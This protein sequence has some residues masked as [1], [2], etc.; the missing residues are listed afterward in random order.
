M[1]KIKEERV[2]AD[3]KR[4][5]EMKTTF[6][7]IEEINEGSAGEEELFEGDILLNKEQQQRRDLGLPIMPDKRGATI[8]ESAYWPNNTLYYFFDDVDP[9]SDADKTVVRGALTSLEKFTCVRFIESND[10]EDYVNV[11]KGDS[12]K[13]WVG[14]QTGIQTLYLGQGCVYTGIIQ[15]EF[16]HALGFWHEQSRYDRDNYVEINWDNIIEGKEGNFEKKLEEHTTHQGFGYDYGSVMHYGFYSFAID[17]TIPTII[18]LRETDET[19]GQREF[20]SD[21]DIDELNRLYECDYYV[22]KGCWFDINL[23][24]LLE[25]LE[26]T[27]NVYLDGHYSMRTEPVRKCAFAAV[28]LGY[29]YFAMRFGG[30]CLVAT[31][32]S[33]Y[34]EEGP[35]DKCVEGLG[36]SDS[37]DVYEVYDPCPL[38]CGSTDNCVMNGFVDGLGYRCLGNGTW[39]EWSDWYGCIPIENN[40]TDGYR[41]GANYRSRICTGGPCYGSTI[42][43]NDCLINCS[44][45]CDVDTYK[46]RNYTVR[47]D[48][49]CNGCV[50]MEGF[51]Y[52]PGAYCGLNDDCDKNECKTTC[53]IGSPLYNDHGE[54]L[55]CNL[56]DYISDFFPY[57]VIT[58]CPASYSC[59]LFNDTVLQVEWG[60]CCPNDNSKWG[61]WTD[62]YGCFP[63]FDCVDGYMT[64]YNYRSRE[65]LEPPCDYPPF[66]YKECSV[67]CSDTCDLGS[68][69]M[70]NYTV[71]YNDHC[72]ACFCIHGYLLCY[73]D[74]CDTLLAGN[75]F[76]QEKECEHT[77]PVG[78]PLHNEHG[79]TLFCYFDEQSAPEG[80]PLFEVIECPPGYSCHF[81]NDTLFDVDW[82]VCC[83]DTSS[84]YCYASGDPHYRT[85]D[86]KYYDFQGDCEYVLTTDGCFGQQGQFSVIVNNYKTY[87]SSTVSM[88]RNATVYIYGMVIELLPGKLVK[89]DGSLVSPPVIPPPSPFV[90]VNLVG[91]YVVIHTGFGLKISWDG[92][93]YIRVDL[94]DVHQGRVCGLCANF[95]NNITDEYMMAD[96]SLTTSVVE[97]GNSWQ[98]NSDCEPAMEA[99]SPCEQNQ[100]ESEAESTCFR[101]L[102]MGELAECISVIDPMVH[103]EMCKMDLCESLPNND[104][105][106]GCDVIASYVAE[107]QSAGVAVGD[108]RSGTE[109]ELKCPTNQ[110]YTACGSAC[111]PTCDQPNPATFCGE[112]C[113]EGCFCDDGL[114]MDEGGICR[115][116]SHCGCYYESNLYRVG[117]VFINYNCT[118]CECFTGG[119]V[120]C[121]DPIC[122]EHAHCNRYTDYYINYDDERHCECDPGYFGDGIICESKY[123]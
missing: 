48:D 68:Y 114:V 120:V 100:F 113:V 6:Q 102:N 36:T 95:N 49:E 54:T 109:C 9:L 53:P 14:R 83:P 52:C 25:S 5:A 56:P 119:V 116:L 47:Y 24:Q 45:V 96:E 86:H 89:I 101:L 90:T 82:S 64:G 106:G 18:A 85:F 26:N 110:T 115:P 23:P 105:A 98:V 75:D 33:S 84:D 39:G 4:L 3:A 41:L 7:V 58:D 35:S 29:P 22:Y 44:D 97:F 81:V 1:E 63:S 107:C 10:V 123:L 103:F 34:Q 72:E 11:I 78:S 108:W 76:C 27:G 57:M 42:D 117:E 70:R 8:Y 21:L 73:Y 50:C 91:Y 111:P 88:T 28:S 66:D 46:L 80:F 31:S 55:F 43:M 61:E 121:T 59:H 112:Q 13:S 67:E 38:N 74:W 122:H 40:C 71:R 37:Y 62:W 94:S 79:E 2:T 32:E 17:N 99:P 118:S 77:C 60:V 19:V 16:L 92:Y 69:Q 65:C 30:E 93:S 12:C 87:P 15:H 51:L 20:A 104:L